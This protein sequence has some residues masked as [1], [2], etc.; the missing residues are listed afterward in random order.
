MRYGVIDYFTNEILEGVPSRDLLAA[1]RDAGDTGAVWAVP[2]DGVWQYAPSD[3][4]EG[5]A[6]ARVVWVEED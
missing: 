2:V 6:D 4:V 5:T 3:E 1:S